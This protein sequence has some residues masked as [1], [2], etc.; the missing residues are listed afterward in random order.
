MVSS[1]GLKIVMTCRDMTKSCVNI[2]KNDGI[3]LMFP[4]WLIYLELVF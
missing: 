3:V 1:A 2:V 4:A